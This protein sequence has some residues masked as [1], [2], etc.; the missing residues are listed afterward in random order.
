MTLVERALDF[1]DA[2]LVFA[3]RTMTL[4]DERR[5]YG[6]PRFITA[7]WPEGAARRAGLDPARW[8]AADHL[9]KGMGM[10]TKKAGGGSRWVDPDEAPRLDREWFERAE[11]RD[12][13]RVIRPARAVGRPRKAA[14]KEAVSIRL[15]PDVL[16]HFR[17]GGPGW[18][19]RI[20]QALRKVAGL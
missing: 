12:G 5:N 17:A 8:R 1:A 15:D 6:E 14:V 13:E 2:G 19:S 16:A 20:N 18:Q 7:G 3:G 9:D 11:I 4:P 10:P